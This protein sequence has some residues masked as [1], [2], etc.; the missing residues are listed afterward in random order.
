MMEI[1]LSLI[2]KIWGI[3]KFPMA[4]FYIG[5]PMFYCLSVF[6]RSV[7]KKKE[8]I[9]WMRK[10]VLIIG[11][12]S[13]LDSAIANEIVMKGSSVVLLGNNNTQLSLT[14]EMLAFFN[15]L[16]KKRIQI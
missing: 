8:K 1:M 16:I 12:P 2:L 6:M 15:K 13:E 3:I 14:K 10:N 9:D 7:M 11:N 5:I 4:V